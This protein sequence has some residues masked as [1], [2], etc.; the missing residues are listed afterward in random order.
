MLSVP[1]KGLQIKMKNRIVRL[2]P[3]AILGSLFFY[4]ILG[5]RRPINHAAV[6][7]PTAERTDAKSTASMDSE[8]V[9]EGS[10]RDIANT[11]LGVSTTPCNTQ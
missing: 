2:V 11:T 1:G 5:G 10:L 9:I 3:V 7:F 8:R 4:T 6:T